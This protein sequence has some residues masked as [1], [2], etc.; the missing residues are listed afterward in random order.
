MDVIVSHMN[1]DFDGLASLLAA[2]KLYPSAEVALSEKQQPTVKSYLAIYRDQLA[3]S[4]YEQIRWSQVKTLILVDVASMNRTGIPV[5]DLSNETK[6]I[7]YDHH[8]PKE[9][10]VQGEER[11]VE[12]VGATITLLMERL[13]KEKVTITPFEAT[14]FGLGLYTDTGNFTF[15][16]TTSRDLYIAYILKGLEM[17]VTLINHFSEQSLTT[18]EKQLFQ[19][20]LTNSEEITISGMTILITTHEQS[21]YQN[22]LA[23]L[24]RRLMES[25]DSDATLSI[26]K[27]KDH[28]YVVARS[29]SNRI[30]FQ[31]LMDDL[32]GGGHSQAASA[33]MK[34]QELNSVVKKVKH[35]INRMI[36]PSVTASEMM[37]KPVKFVSPY[38]S[39]DEVLERMY[40][41]GHTGFP[42]LNEDGYLIG[43]ISRRD[44]D[45][46]THHGLGHAP[47]KAYMSTQIVT[48]E[49]TSSL[50]EI[51]T[52]MMKH[53]IGRIPIMLNQN[54]V[55][56]VSRT[57]VIEQLHRK[58]RPVTDQSIV[59]KMQA[60]LPPDTYNLLREI[61]AIADSHGI[62][63]YL[64]GG[65]VRDFLLN[66][67][68][69]DI[70][71]VVEGD[72]ISFAH[73]IREQ[74]GG[75]IKT[76][77]QFATATWTTPTNI[78]LDI[79]TCRTEYYDAPAALP[80]VRASNIREDL[81]RRDFSINALALQIN[82]SDFGKLLDFF[83]GQEDMDNKEIR[84]L[85]NLSFIED[86]TRIV[87]AIR[88][89]LR[90]D[91][92]L[93]K[94][95]E[96]LALNA[97]Y[98]LK[99]VSATRFLR[100]IQLL[101]NEE[102]IIRGVKLLDSLH[103]WQSLFNLKPTIESLM[104]LEQVI[105]Y[106]F[107]DAFIVILT[108]NYGQ[109]NWKQKVKRYSLTT[110][111]NQL[112]QQLEAMQTVPLSKNETMSSIHNRYHMFKEDTIL[113][114]TILTENTLLRNYV[115]KREQLKPLLTGQ[116]LLMQGI[117]PGPIFSD[118]LHQLTCFQL[119]NEIINRNDALTWL[120]A[121]RKNNL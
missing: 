114:Y 25:T 116:D 19:I 55:G 93:A 64:I 16:Q 86:P 18:E 57:D 117:K 87:R 44:V 98:L 49:P 9:D 89:A 20:L 13:L 17:D 81:R 103:V 62:N 45:K 23:T 75:Q 104:K 82:K 76:H 67:L 73:T 46:A 52:T 6:T 84:I 88:F 121:K 5:D 101:I 99:Q 65:I 8:P 29:S 119:D 78:K 96:E 41:Y 30:D 66:R 4:T 95:T 1:L 105:A 56:I 27:M 109:H 50:E 60:Q 11:Y 40:Q 14:L 24:T 115:E 77:E 42:V 10:D 53:N 34:K 35:V 113:L 22:G 58:S 51:Q 59:T 33:T 63:V 108:L 120:Q 92:T 111:Q 48:L 26:V 74:L 28:V 54:V 12:Q 36:K 112:I 102:T 21:T 3:L 94:Q 68:N 69:E 80:T 38:D 100:E 83:Q 97:S 91:Y 71:L 2:K 110:K 37:A 107:N 47:V 90:F 39:I 43:V 7:L 118:I 85:H 31:P 106:H 79:V 61:G 15:K 70:D 32:G 72:G